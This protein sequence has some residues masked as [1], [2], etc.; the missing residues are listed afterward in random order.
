MLA[1]LGAALGVAI[2]VE[3]ARRRSTVAA[4]RF[5]GAVGAL[6]RPR[7]R[8]GLAGATWLLLGF[9]MAVL[10]APVA[11]AVT[12]MWAVSAG[13]ASAAVVGRIVGGPRLLGEKTWAGTLAALAMTA[14]GAW[15]LAGLAWPVA[16]LAGATAAAAE[17]PSGPIDD[18]LRIALSVTAVTYIAII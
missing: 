10:A 6:L 2:V 8:A 4:S 15:G 17:L 7:D 12:G 11:A 5:E 18:N 16:L 9:L 14:A 1:L 13:D 3:V